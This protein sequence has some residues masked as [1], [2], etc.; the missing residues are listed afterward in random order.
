MAE[1]GHPCPEAIYQL[2]AVRSALV[3]AEQLHDEQGRAAAAG[4]DGR[5]RYR[6]RLITLGDPAEGEP[7]TAR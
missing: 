6:A 2:R 3:Q 7:E 5:H 1:E 4:N